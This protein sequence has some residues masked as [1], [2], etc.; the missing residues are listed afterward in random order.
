MQVTQGR[1]QT[2]EECLK[3]SSV[4]CSLDLSLVTKSPPCLLW[5][6]RPPSTVGRA[7]WKKLCL[8]TR[9]L[10]VQLQPATLRSNLRQVACRTLCDACRWCT[11]TRCLWCDGCPSASIICNAQ[12]WWQWLACL[13]TPWCCPSIIYAVFLC[14]D[15]LPPLHEV[16]FYAAYHL[17]ILRHLTGDRQ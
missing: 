14:K 13:S 9:R 3:R 6:L 8:V 5:Q 1:R 17:D 15:H 12:Q 16:W 4:D 11:P 7:Q 2:L 10:R